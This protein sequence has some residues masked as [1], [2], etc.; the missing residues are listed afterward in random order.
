MKITSEL[1]EFQKQT[2]EWMG[3]HEARYDGG[4]LMN[5]TGT[6]KCICILANFINSPLKTLIIC[7]P[8]LIDN[9]INEIAKH[10]DIPLDRIVKYH[11]SNR[12]NTK[13]N[14][15]HLIFITSYSII[16]NEFEQGSE[17][18]SFVNKSLFNKI[19]FGRIVL[20][21]AHYIRNAYSC[22]NKSIMFLNEKSDPFVKKWIVTA[23]PL[24][25]GHDDAYS[26]FKFLGYEG[27]DN[28]QIWREIIPKSIEGY[29]KLND[30]FKKY[31]L[32]LKKQNVLKELSLKNEQV[33][34]IQFN[35]IEKE[36]Y[37]VLKEYSQS[38][39]K[40]LT[41]NIEKLTKKTFQHSAMKKIL[42]S[43]IMVYILRLRQ[44]CNSPWLILQTMERL[45]KSSTIETAIERLKYYNESKEEDDEECPICYDTVANY[46]A[47]PCGHKCCNE[48]WKKMF[49]AGIFNCPKCRC[50]VENIESI[51]ET[52]EISNESSIYQSSKI[53]TLIDVTCKI[54]N[55]NEKIVIVSQW[56]KMLDIIKECFDNNESLKNIK[57]I[58]LQGNVPLKSRSEFIYQFQN[59]PNVKICFLSL[60]S[61]AEGINL[62]ASNHLVLFESWWN[63]S[64]MIQVMDRIHRIGQ[65]KKVYIYKFK[66]KDSIEESIE[67]LVIHKDKM[68]NL[69][70][71]KW[72]PFNNKS[73]DDSWINNII[74]LIN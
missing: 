62:V 39:M 10:T 16:T 63:N 37:N 22:V 57:S 55:N 23:T 9:W 4:L 31:G 21:E 40:L 53:N 43:N 59:D 19:K 15:D 3:K 32:S 65:T 58:T 48:C 41:N 67:K 14:D 17:S 34:E 51:N 7:P 6:G 45:K 33:L 73:Y 25:N 2:I 71:N 1:K 27:I 50:K 11:G 56:V 70:L 38:R 13:L 35:D 72:T 44:A 18:D 24:F 64:K 42:Q 8:I 26:Y 46:I 52:Q 68:S 30:L 47:D 49:N 20:D 36:F 5:D 66:I 12:F 54:I 74:K 69:I 60:T 29:K 61:S 28:K